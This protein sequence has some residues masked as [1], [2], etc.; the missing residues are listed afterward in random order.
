MVRFAGL[1]LIYSL[2]FCGGG[3]WGGVYNIFSDTLVYLIISWEHVVSF[4][5]PLKNK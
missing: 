5:D 3:G 2:S 1:G 4:I